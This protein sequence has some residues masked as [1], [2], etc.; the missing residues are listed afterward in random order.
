MRSLS[1]KSI[2][3]PFMSREDDTVTVSALE[4]AI[5]TNIDWKPFQ[6]LEMKRTDW[7]GM[8]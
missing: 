5:Q 1:L 3:Q 8:G 6:I 7:N 2:V 4:L